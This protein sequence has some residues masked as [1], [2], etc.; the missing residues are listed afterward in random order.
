MQCLGVTD[1]TVAAWEAATKRILGLLEDHLD[2][3]GSSPQ[4][5]QY[6]L[7]PKPSVADFGLIGPLWAHLLCDPVPAH[8]MKS[9]FPLVAEWTRTLHEQVSE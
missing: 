4:R 8:M 2:I 6:L 9:Q 3:H 7:G 5:M 1:Q